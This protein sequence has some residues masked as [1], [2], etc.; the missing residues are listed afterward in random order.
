MGILNVVPHGAPKAAVEGV[1]EA[2]EVK[3]PEV[4]EKV[5]ADKSLVEMAKREKAMRMQAREMAAMKQAIAQREAEYK[6]LQAEL[7]KEKG[8]KS[9]L[10]SNPWDAFIEAGYSPE[11]ATAAMLNQPTQESME[12]K[13]LRAELASIKA[14]Q[15]SFKQSAKQSQEQAYNQTKTQLKSE[16][17]RLAKGNEAFELIDAMEAHDQVVDRIE[18]VYNETGQLID[19]EEAAKYVEDNL[20]E[21]VQK[22]VKLKKLQKLLSPQEPQAHQVNP[23]QKLSTLS[24]QHSASSSRLTAKDRRERAIAAF[25]GQLK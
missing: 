14:E 25:N 16:V 3:N 4:T 6:A 1:Q 15:E 10:K 20:M 13:Q 12:L 19:V 18:E 8:F 22:V 5:D 23:A 11:E 17:T 2:V 9:K 7:D 24:N 21:E